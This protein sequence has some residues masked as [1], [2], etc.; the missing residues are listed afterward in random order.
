MVVKV[1]FS[2]V[3]VTAAS[4]L[5]SM[6]LHDAG[7]VVSSTLWASIHLPDCSLENHPTPSC[8]PGSASS[9]PR[10]RKEAV[11]ACSPF[12]GHISGGMYHVH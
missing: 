1:Y 2:H 3:P 8:A 11:T 10:G 5:H 6:R 9:Q 4:S 7:D 12:K